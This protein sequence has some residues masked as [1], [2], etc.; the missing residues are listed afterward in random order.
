[1]IYLFPV[2]PGR[3]HPYRVFETVKVANKAV[4]QRSRCHS[5]GLPGS[6]P[7]SDRSSCNST[8][9]TS[10]YG[11]DNASITLED[12]ASSSNTQ[13]EESRCVYEVYFFVTK[14]L[15]H[16]VYVRNM[17]ASEHLSGCLWYSSSLFYNCCSSSEKTEQ[18]QLICHTFM[19]SF[20]INLRLV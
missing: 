3:N 18:Q 1:M 14:G 6:S 19:F 16:G 10:Y 15:F 11:S 5:P 9:R 17:V 12:K 7:V 8:P 20:Q 4:R 13:K 2:C